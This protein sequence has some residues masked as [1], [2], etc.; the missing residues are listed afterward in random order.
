MRRNSR[1]KL[2]LQ[3]GRS[4][5]SD[6]AGGLSTPCQVANEGGGWPAWAGRLWAGWRLL[7]GT[8]THGCNRGLR[9][10]RSPGV[11]LWL[12]EFWRP[13]VGRLTFGCSAMTLCRS[14][15]FALLAEC[16]HCSGC[17]ANVVPAIGLLHLARKLWPIRAIVLTSSHCLCSRFCS[18]G[19]RRGSASVSR[20]PVLLPSRVALVSQAG[21]CDVSL[22]LSRS[23]IA[24]PSRPFHCTLSS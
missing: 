22:S 8:L 16:L 24:P 3:A 5:L 10:A 13:V 17:W 18:P 20:P 1:K 12:G 19:I 7:L 21:K 4:K 11:N 6:E 2:K 15:P 9:W 14:A 23:R